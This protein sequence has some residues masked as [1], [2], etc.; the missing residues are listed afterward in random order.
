MTALMMK[1]ITIR[2]LVTMLNVISAGKAFEAV[3]GSPVATAKTTKET[4]VTKDGRQ[5]SEKMMSES[6][7]L[8]ARTEV[9]R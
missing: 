1:G 5:L 2:G 6:Q 4:A 9:P 8:C 3:S 7:M